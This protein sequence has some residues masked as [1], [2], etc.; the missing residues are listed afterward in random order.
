MKQE[1]LL[2]VHIISPKQDFYQGPALSVSSVNSSGKFDI[3]P[4]HANFITLIQNQPIIVRVPGQGAL[5]FK[6]PIA[7]LSVTNNQ[8]NIFTDIQL[9][10]KKS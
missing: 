9:N 7:I 3:L 6:F 1:N 5:T 8:V 10:I 2:Q 4:Q